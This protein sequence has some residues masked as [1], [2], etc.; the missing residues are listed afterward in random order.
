MAR[1]GQPL[2]WFDERRVGPETTTEEL[3]K[4]IVEDLSGGMRM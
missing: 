1:R 2:P 3:V 4:I